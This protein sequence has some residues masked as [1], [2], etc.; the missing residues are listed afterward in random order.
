MKDVDKE[1]LV[2]MARELAS[3]K[4][5][6]HFHFL[7]KNCQFNKRSDKVA[8]ILENEETNENFVTYFD[9]K[10]KELMIFENLFYNRPEDFSQY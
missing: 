1:E 4:T 7:T 3:K 10:P 5:K 8:I 9:E 2:K 6:W